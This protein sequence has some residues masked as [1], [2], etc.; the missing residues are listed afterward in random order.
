MNLIS[1]TFDVCGV[2]KVRKV[3]SFWPQISKFFSFACSFPPALPSPM[4]MLL[5]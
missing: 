1:A 5:S 3:V 4:Y 2:L